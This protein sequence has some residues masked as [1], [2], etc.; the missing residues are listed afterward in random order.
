ME[1][2]EGKLYFIKDEF[3]EKYNPKYHLMENKT[4]G[5]KRPTYFCFRDKKEKDILWF[6]PMSSKYDKYLEIYEYIKQKRGKEPN[7]FVFARN[8]AGKKTVFLIQNMFPTL[9]KYIEEEY[10]KAGIS[11]KVPKAVKE[12]IDR[13]TR[14]IFTYTNRGIVATFTNLPEFIKEIRAELIQDRVNKG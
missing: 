12:E 2:I 5:T 14:D 10:K 4:Q 9:A 13:K 1:I 11:I 8:V 7:N 6:V 3:I